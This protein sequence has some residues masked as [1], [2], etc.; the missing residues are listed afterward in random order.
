MA[1]AN[2]LDEETNERACDDAGPA[3]PAGSADGV[4]IRGDIIEFLG[5][6]KCEACR[7][8]E[9]DCIIKRGANACL[10]C[11][12]AERTCVFER[13]M[14]VRGFVNGFT[15][16]SLLAKDDCY[17]LVQDKPPADRVYACTGPSH[18]RYPPLSR[19]ADGGRET[20]RPL[21]LLHHVNHSSSSL[22]KILPASSDTSHNIPNTKRRTPPEV[23]ETGR[24]NSVQV[25]NMDMSRSKRRRRQFS[26]HEKQYIQSVRKFGACLEC[27][28]GKRKVGGTVRSLKVGSADRQQCTHVPSVPPDQ[29]RKENHEAFPA[30]SPSIQKQ[31]LGATLV[32]E[33]T[34]STTTPQDRAKGLYWESPMTSHHPLPQA[35]KAPVSKS[36]PYYT[37]EKVMCPKCNVRP[38]GYRGEHELVRHM[39]REHSAKV[40]KWKCVDASNDG[41][42]LA[43]C[44][45]CDDGKLYNAYYNAAAHLRRRH[46]DKKANPKRGRHEVTDGSE[47]SMDFLKSYM[48]EVEVD[49]EAQGESEL[50]EHEQADER[51]AV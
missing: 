15:W 6:K 22:A 47:L 7:S 16:E 11:S 25:F 39:N 26:E 37:V 32:D 51:L 49:N 30:Q 38:D 43:G 14:R 34:G 42:L 40:K 1:A 31:G 48:Q 36:Q 50:E 28:N 21:P 20:Q 2:V 19:P 18:T 27:K 29:D 10:L 41:E 5:Q 45:A 23:S 24:T 8:R 4:V 3:G 9:R 35:S 33:S 13:Q 12:D 44:R 17:D 46:F